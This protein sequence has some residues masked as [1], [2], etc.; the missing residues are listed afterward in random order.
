M[1]LIARLLEAGPGTAV[2]E[3]EP[4]SW[5]LGAADGRVL[6]SALIECVA[7]AAA[8]CKAAAGG[9][10]APAAPGLLAGVSGFR[11]I[12]RPAVG[13]RLTVRIREDRQLGPFCLVTG[14]VEAGGETVAEG[15][16][17]LY[18]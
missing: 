18:G 14:R 15:Q 10:A 16:L 13:E 11:V 2:A 6:E 8:A 9:G 1:L 12:R 4:A 7:Q 5:G 3:A 17:K